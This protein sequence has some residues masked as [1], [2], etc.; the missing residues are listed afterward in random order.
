MKDK[1]QEAVNKFEQDLVSAGVDP[2]NV[3]YDVLS[4]VR[5]A[6]WSEL[7]SIANTEIE[8]FKQKILEWIYRNHDHHEGAE[9]RVAT[10]D[11]DNNTMSAFED[12]Q[13]TAL[14]NDGDKPYVNS[15]DLEK[16][17]KELK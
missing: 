3:D 13:S 15:L 14:C 12:E 10:L 1:I 4:E 5:I 16:F 2:S 7:E 6:H 11:L 9:G 17:I 8:S